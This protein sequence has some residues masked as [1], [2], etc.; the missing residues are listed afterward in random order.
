MQ[1][2]FQK[3]KAAANSVA[4]SQISNVRTVKAF[5]QEKGSLKA[6]SEKNDEVY[7]V[8]VKKANIWGWMMFYI[9]FFTTGSLACLILF[10]SS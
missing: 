8:A 10:V 5:A 9:K 7:E 1:S 3:A 2:L 6:F 4:E